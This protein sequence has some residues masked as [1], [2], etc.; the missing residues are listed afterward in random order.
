MNSSGYELA[1]VSGPS[2]DLAP[3]EIDAYFRKSG[4]V[5]IA[6]TV[7]EILEEQLAAKLA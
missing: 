6:L 4:K 2:P 1:T 3:C 5:I 7:K